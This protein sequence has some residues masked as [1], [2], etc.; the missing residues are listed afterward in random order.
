MKKCTYTALI[1]VGL[2]GGIP[3]FCGQSGQKKPLTYYQRAQ[4]A[5]GTVAKGAKSV[6][7]GAQQCFGA[8]CAATEPVVAPIK[9]CFGAACAAT[10]PLGS[11][12]ASYGAG[13]ISDYMARKYFPHSTSGSYLGKALNIGVAGTTFALSQLASMQASRT[14]AQSGSE[15]KQN[16]ELQQK[17]RNTDLGNGIKALPNWQYYVSL[18]SK[19]CAASN[20]VFSFAE[21]NRR[22]PQDIE[23]IVNQFERLQLAQQNTNTQDLVEAQLMRDMVKARMECGAPNIEWDIF[24]C[25]WIDGYGDVYLNYKYQ[26]FRDGLSDNFKN[27]FFRADARPQSCMTTAWQYCVMPSPKIEQAI[28]EGSKGSSQEVQNLRRE[29]RILQERNDQL[30]ERI[31]Q[32]QKELAQKEIEAL[33]F[34]PEPLKVP[35]PRPISEKQLETL[36]ERGGKVPGITTPRTGSPIKRTGSPAKKPVAQKKSSTRSTSPATRGRSMT[37]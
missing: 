24:L 35:I 20:V 4:Q 11:I 3:L 25:Y 8:V 22:S 12:A 13:Q 30:Q 16:V 32:Y 1:M 14:V 23:W 5:A 7:K 27:T 19:I 18:F 6:A 15:Y 17:Y 21:L 2:I 36:V 33:E 31:R 10:G 26:G 34:K 37:R 9:K 28:E 29:V